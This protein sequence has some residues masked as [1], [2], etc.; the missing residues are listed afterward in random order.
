MG[1]PAAISCGS[2]FSLLAAVIHSEPVTAHLRAG[3]RNA[4]PHASAGQE[5]PGGPLSV[6]GRQTGLNS[7]PPSVGL[8]KRPTQMALAL[9][10]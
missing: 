3:A 6:V 8:A 1:E 5:E 9:F 2:F 10:R 7:F 4:L